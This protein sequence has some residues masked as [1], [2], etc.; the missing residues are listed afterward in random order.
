MIPTLYDVRLA[1]ERFRDLRHDAA[2]YR[3][4][5]A[6]S[7]AAVPGPSPF[8]RVR[9]LMARLRLLRPLTDRAEAPA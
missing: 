5:Q 3:L 2:I 4:V 1:E 9:T 6:N 7:R 8:L